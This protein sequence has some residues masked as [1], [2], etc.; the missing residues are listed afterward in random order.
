MIHRTFVVATLLALLVMRLP[1]PG[2]S[3]AASDP[4]A[5]TVEAARLLALLLD[6]GRL[7][8]GDYQP[9]INDPAKGDKN[10]GPAVFETQLA[11]KFLER[12]G[13][14]LSTLAT[15]AVPDSSKRAL[16]ILVET[17]KQV[18]AEA[19]GVINIPGIGF[20]GFI[21]A[22]FATS[23]AN[24]FRSHTG[25]YLRQTMTAPRN[26]RNQPAE[27][28]IEMLKKF[29]EQGT[30]SKGQGPVSEL[31]EDKKTV[32]VML[33]LYYNKTCL[34]CHGEPKGERD[35]SGF[36]REGAKEGDLGGAISVKMEIP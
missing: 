3:L 13:V 35:V 16:P 7:V 22:T 17:E 12:T 29:A 18:V 34:P 6:T 32:R 20:K 5:D 31:S 8:L 14:D 15:A 2:H 4:Q 24:R 21:P 26:P 36:L 25:I 23:T 33:P 30:G 27:Y 10:F 1:F 11:A 19:Q 28:E 9:V